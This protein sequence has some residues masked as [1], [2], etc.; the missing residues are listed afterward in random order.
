MTFITG[1]HKQED[2]WT[3]FK[4]GLPPFKTPILIDSGDGIDYF[5]IV[6]RLEKPMRM[7]FESE[8]FCNYQEHGG[9]GL[10]LS[11]PDPDEKWLDL[12]ELKK[13]SQSASPLI[14]SS[15]NQ[16]KTPDGTA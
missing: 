15:K 9:E 11:D 14:N 13:A 8:E 2:M 16:E 1:W 7:Y 3:K 6:E 10:F 4:D 5:R 12:L